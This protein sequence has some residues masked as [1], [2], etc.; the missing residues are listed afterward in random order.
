M[1]SKTEAL[2]LTR[3][4]FVAGAGSVVTS[5]FM[6]VVDNSI[7]SVHSPRP[8]ATHT[9]IMDVRSGSIQYNDKDLSVSKGDVVHWQAKTRGSKHHLSVIFS[10]TTPFTDNHNP[11]YGFYG[12]QDDENHGGIGKNASIDTNASGTYKYWVLVGDDDNGGIFPDDPK[13]IV[14]GG[15]PA[16]ADLLAAKEYLERAVISDPSLKDR[17]APLEEKLFQVISSLTKETSK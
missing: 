15:N 5:G 13:I 10:P 9:V 16:L 7:A 1:P 6:I 2:H 8:P 14:G 12:S 4:E 11:V 17:L 3:R